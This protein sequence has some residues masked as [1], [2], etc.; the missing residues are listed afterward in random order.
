M[1]WTQI[2]TTVLTLLIPTGG[3]MAIFTAREKK[4]EMALNNMNKI[5]EQWAAFS[6]KEEERRKELKADID[7]KDDKID[8]LHR[9][10]SRLRNEL[11]NE[12]TERAKADLMKCI[13]IKCVDRHPPFAQSSNTRENGNNQ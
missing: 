1:D 11:D 13:R 8:E 2:I 10:L 3:I 9:E 7:K 12:R 5:N 6:S 4:T